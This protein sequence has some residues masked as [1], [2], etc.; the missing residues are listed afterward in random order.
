M[1]FILFIF[2]TFFGFAYWNITTPTTTQTYTIID[3]QDV[4]KES[5]A[6]GAEVYADFC[7]QCHMAEGEGVP[8]S[9]PPLAKSDWI[10]N[11][12]K[13]SIQAIKYGLKGEITVNG[14]TYN[15]IM[16][17]MGLEDEEIADVMNYIMNNWGNTQKNIVTP[18]EVAK[19]KKS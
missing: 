7:M 19:V 16:T 3:T 15:N 12:R 8:N 6:R 1:K 18:A 5:V 4:L 14:K 17:P 2:S 13:A 11:K 9:F 10:K